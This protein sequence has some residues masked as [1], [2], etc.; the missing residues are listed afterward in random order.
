MTAEYIINITGKVNAL[1][2]DLESAK[3]PITKYSVD[4]KLQG[5]LEGI[6]ILLDTLDY[7]DVHAKVLSEMITIW[8]DHR[9]DFWDAQLINQ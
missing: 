4:D 1:F 7:D 5:L 3:N 8:K 6:D 9:V 2:K